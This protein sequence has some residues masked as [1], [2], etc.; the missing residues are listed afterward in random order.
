M[1]V[2][3]FSKLYAESSRSAILQ[4]ISPFFYHFLRYIPILPK[5]PSCIIDY[6]LLFLV[7]HF[8]CAIPLTWTSSTILVYW[9]FVLHVLS[10]T[11]HILYTFSKLPYTLF[12]IPQK[13]GYWFPLIDDSPIFISSSTPQIH[14]KT[15]LPGYLSEFLMLFTT[16]FFILILS[17]ILHHKFWR[18]TISI[19]LTKL[20]TILTNSHTL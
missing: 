8:A 3:L 9:I 2:L 20:N 19:S 7:C 6:T 17:V 12:K 1:L 16:F 13:I 18:F 15:H 11:L 10:Q 14:F 5:M 4:I